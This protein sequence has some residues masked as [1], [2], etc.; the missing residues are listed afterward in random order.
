MVQLSAF[1]TPQFDWA[2]SYLDS[3]PRPLAPVFA[4]EIAADAILRAAVHPQREY[5]VG[6]PAMKT[7]IGARLVPA[8]ADWLS[9]RMAYDGQMSDERSSP[10][11]GNLFAPIARDAGA[12]G[13]FGAESKRTS[14]QWWLTTHR[15]PAVAA[16]A[17]FAIALLTVLGLD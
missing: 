5:W 4:P 15:L 17:V 2:R 8:L 6:W 1:N 9:S 11:E 10:R 13:R 14:V 3:D 12:T 7:I 16:V